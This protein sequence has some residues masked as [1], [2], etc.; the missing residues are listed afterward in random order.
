MGASDENTTSINEVVFFLSKVSPEQLNE[1]SEKY[2]E[3]SNDLIPG[4]IAG[5]D[6]TPCTDSEYLI[7]KSELVIGALKL[8]KS[9]SEK[10]LIHVSEAIKKSKRKRLL[11]QI[12]VILG[13]SSLLAAVAFKQQTLEILTSLITLSAAILGVLADNNEKTLSSSEENIHEI[14]LKIGSAVFSAH[15]ISNNLQVAINAKQNNDKLINLINEGNR[16]C[17][18]LNRYLVQTLGKTIYSNKKP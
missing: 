8:A 18:E 2:P 6:D 12:F 10:A 11:S 17:E 16:V 1:A 5:S 14:F 15:D 3:L 7:A 13:S 9:E 4:V